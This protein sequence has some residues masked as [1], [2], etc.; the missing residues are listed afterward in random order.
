MA[1]IDDSA[2]VLARYREARR[3]PPQLQ[4]TVRARLAREIA[5]V[6]ATPTRA[7]P[8]KGQVFV[9]AAA[10]L[11]AAAAVV[12]LWQSLGDATVLAR[13]ETREQ[14]D[15]DGRAAATRGDV[16]APAVAPAELP[17]VSPT[18]V[19]TPAPE[20]TLPTTVRASTKA[21]PPPRTSPSSALA[22]E[23]AGLAEIRMLVEGGDNRGAL[24]AIT[25]HRAAFPSGQLGRERD[26]LTIEALCHGGDPAT[27]QT[28]ARAFVGAHP[29][30]TALA[31][32][33]ATCR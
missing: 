21:E 13:S 20:P 26:A 24:A 16:R 32:L 11:A 27:A 10:V 28:R 2:R 30:S 7:T 8:A 17:A 23:L 6:T 4:T 29:E 25:A 3:A 1:E 31:K 9:I 12:L 14:A 33:P 5:G 19:S 15:Y 22:A 18:I